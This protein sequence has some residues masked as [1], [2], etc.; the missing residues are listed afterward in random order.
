MGGISGIYILDI[1][2]RLI[3]CRTYKTDILT[4]VCDAFYENVILQDSSSVKPVFHVDGCTF[5]WVLRNGIYFIAVASTNYNVSLSLSFLYRFVQVLTSYFKH[6]SEESI[7]D[8]FV[9]VYEL[10]D[11]MIDNGYPQATEVNILREFIKNKYHQLSISDVHPPTAMTNTVSWRSE[12]IKH[13]KNEIFLDVIESLDIVVS[14]SGTVLRSEIRGCLKMKS[15]LSGMPELFLGL[16]DKAIFDIT[17]KGDLANESTNY[18]TGS[19][20]HVKTVEMEDVKFHQCV[21]LAKFESDRTISFIPPDGEFDL[22]TYRLNSYVKPLFSADVT[23]YNKSSSKID[24]AVKALSQF[25][26]KSIANN[27]EFHIPVPSDVN[28]P[29]FKP[30]IGTVKY[31]PDMDAIV[32]TIKQF[33]GEKEYVM[34]ASFGLPSVSDDSRDTFSKNPVKVKFEIPYFTVSGISVKHLRITESC[35]YKALPWVRYITKNGDYQLRMS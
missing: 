19:V 25:R 5:C 14:V 28:C 13:K 4:N 26:S 2:G 35:G 29:V 23:V 34:H 22:M 15:Y 30:S 33:Q 8:N 21:Q 31:F 32:W 3:I 1:K 18:S 10:L 12:G 27:V 11:E 17:S 7:K 16:N 24:F 9:V 6:L 20:P